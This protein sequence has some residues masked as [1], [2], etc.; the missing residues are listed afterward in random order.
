MKTENYGKLLFTLLIAWFTFSLVESSLHLFATRPDQPP[1]PILLAVLTP[2]LLFYVWFRSST[3]FREFVLS[4]NLQALTFAQSWRIAGFVFLVLYTYGIL[5]GSFALPAGWGDI[6]I[7]ITAP[8][9]AL[10]LAKPGHRFGFILWQALGI[11]DLV[12]AVGSGAASRLIEPQ[13]VPTSPMTLLPLSLIPTFAVPLMLI[14]HVIS[15]AQAKRWS[16]Q[17][18]P[19]VVTRTSLGTI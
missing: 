13:A 9:V 1:L 10:R 8:F 15:I 12:V 16:S 19:D 4:L 5:P 6:A 18:H 11:L 3:G 14:L 7:G 17:T 2:V